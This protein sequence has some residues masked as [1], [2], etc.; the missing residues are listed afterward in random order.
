[1]AGHSAGNG[2]AAPD[3][4]LTFAKFLFVRPHHDE[5]AVRARV[6]SAGAA[7]GRG[8]FNDFDADGARDAQPQETIHFLTASSY[9]RGDGLAA[10]Q[11]VVQISGNYRPRL[12]DV[13][14]EMRRRIGGDAILTA[15]DGALRA[16]RYTSAEMYAYAYQAALPRTS[17]RIT[18]NAII[19]PINKHRAW[20]EKPALDRHIYFY[21]HVD[22]ASGCP[23]KG[24]A[25]AAEPGIS[26]IFRRLYHNPDG[27]E[28]A[29]EFD[30]ISYFECA[31]EHLPVYD[32]ICQALRDERQNPEWRFVTEGPEWRGRR[33]L[34]W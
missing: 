1:M 15:L 18:R 32:R 31:D 16:P 23:V 33:V 20:W 3:A 30:F 17:G 10:A 28:R 7:I 26:S 27:Y 24:H 8:F 19:L 5:E 14:K 12:L 4:N 2:Q 11:Y 25:R 34:R 21:P 9:V 29:D 6:K 22:H 13:E